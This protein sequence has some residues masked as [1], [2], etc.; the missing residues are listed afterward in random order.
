MYL[1]HLRSRGPI[2]RDRWLTLATLA[3]AAV[4]VAGLQFTSAALLPPG[5]TATI[6]GI[7]VGLVFGTVASWFERR[8][9]GEE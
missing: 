8:R 2:S 4:V 3:I 5:K 1:P 9:A 6:G 7:A